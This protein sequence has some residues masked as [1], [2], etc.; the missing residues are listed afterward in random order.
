MTE[1]IHTCTVCDRKRMSLSNCL[2]SKVVRIPSGQACYRIQL[3][4]NMYKFL[5]CYL[6][7]S[8]TLTTHK[9][10][11]NIYIPPMHTY[12]TSWYSSNPWCD[13]SLPSPLS[14]MPPNGA[15]SVEMTPSFTPTM[16]YSKASDTR[17]HRP[18]SRL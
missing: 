2:G 15:T 9:R 5:A 16:P 4:I 10:Q 11:K 1:R 18:T 6:Y 7:T 8:L 13:P 17:K 3:Y 14:L 12:L